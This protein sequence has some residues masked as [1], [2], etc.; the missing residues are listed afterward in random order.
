MDPH[1]RSYLGARLPPD[2]RDTAARAQLEVKRRL[3][4]VPARWTP[5]SEMALILLPLGE[6]S[7]AR[8]QEALAAARLVCRERA[9]LALRLQGYVGIPNQVQPREI[10]IGLG[11]EVEGLFELQERLCQ[12]L[13]PY[14]AIPSKMPPLAI[15]V[16]RLRTDTPAA[17]TEAGQTLRRLN[18][19][20][21]APFRLDQ[22]EL[23]VSEA[24]AEG[25]SLRTFGQVTMS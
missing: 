23:M 2:A 9:P 25:V 8:L 16:G 14:A 18:L 10:A 13:T 1:Y 24:G 21:Q 12:A 3:A 22:L 5:P 11:G 17:R 7:D 20:G 19:E 4:S 6:I 15:E